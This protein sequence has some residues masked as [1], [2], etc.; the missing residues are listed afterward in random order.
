MGV[1]YKGID[2]SKHNGAINW[3]KIKAAGVDFAIIR[4]GLGRSA[5]S[6]RD[7][8]FERNYTESKRVGIPIGVYH[9][10]YAQSV[11]AAEMEADFCIEILKGKKFEFPIYFDIEEKTQ[12]ALSMDLCGKMIVAFC[13]KLER[14]GYW[15]GMYSYD[16]FFKTNIPDD[17]EK[18]YAVWVAKVPSK[19]KDNGSTRLKP[20]YATAY[21]MHQYTWRAKINGSSAETDA[22]ICT[23][24][25]PTLIKAKGLN[26]YGKAPETTYCG[27]VTGI[28]AADVEILK[29]A[30]KRAGYNIFITKE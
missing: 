15:A 27:A 28:R 24:D 25:Y 4:S 5:P 6:Q 2:V 12:A 13:S 26:G 3:D 18:R 11:E 22:N 17:I 10:S 8:Q 29:A 14:A 20:Q 7:P 16:C 21:Q 9:Y 30:V 1:E 19:N 23:V